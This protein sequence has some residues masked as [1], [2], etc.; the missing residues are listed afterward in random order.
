MI[1]HPQF[2]FITN[3]GS[4]TITAYTGTSQNVVIPCQ[5]NGYSV[6]C[7]GPNA[8][9][10][11][12]FTNIIIPE[13]ITAIGDYAFESTLL[14]S[15]T[16][17]NSLL[18]IGNSAFLNCWLMT[19]VNFGNSLTN[20]GT[21]EDDQGVFYLTELTSVTIPNSV[22]TIGSW[23]FSIGNPSL[24]NVIIGTNVAS[25]G[26][27]VF[28]SDSR[29]P[30]ITIPDSVTSIGSYAFG[31]CNSLGHAILGRGVSN[32]GDHA[33]YYDIG[34]ANVTVPG[35]I[36]NWGD[37]AFYNCTSLQ[38]VT[39]AEG[40]TIIG[41]YAFQ[42][43]TKLTNCAIPN[44][45]TNIG[46][47]A[48]ADTSLISVTIPGS[49]ENIG[50][51]AYSSCTW[52]A[53]VIINPG[54][55]SIGNGV[56][57]NCPDFLTNV[58]LPNTLTSIGTNAFEYCASLLSITIP[59]SVTNLAAGA[60]FDTTFPY[61]IYFT[62]NAPTLGTNV[63]GSFLEEGQQPGPPYRAAISATLYY[64][65][66]TTGWSS[67]YG[68]YTDILWNPQALTGDGFFGVRTNRF[69]FNINGSSNVM[70]VV[71]ACTNLANPVWQALGTYTLTNS[72]IYFSDPRYT[73]Y[74]GRFYRFSSP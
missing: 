36:T 51:G 40:D 18:S 38:S 73:N 48:F 61:G 42:N 10:D 7:I 5:T 33:F 13:G 35:G 16:L 14:G 37:Y 23:A 30:S 71:E 12:D 20:I 50:D 58:T 21:A 67:N 6:T 1:V 11:D 59:S 54:V 9:M 3:N 52:L 29:L 27:H 43:C 68:G 55:T 72:P 57:Q 24:T 44:T 65:P 62:G 66:G 17:P 53:N 39:L 15:I 26:E 64:L 60:F 47:F 41:N 31:W 34:L 25:I 49:V 19:S 28:D 46:A 22:R 4:I 74:L 45:V 2:T 69:G 63:F 8:F 70:F 32:L 56:F